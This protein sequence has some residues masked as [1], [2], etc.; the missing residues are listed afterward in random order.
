MPT[1]CN[2]LSA[3]AAKQFPY[4][5]Q[6]DANDHYVRRLRDLLDTAGGKVV[7]LTGAGVSTDS[8]IPDYRGP[9]GSYSWGHK[10]MTHDEFLSSEGNQKR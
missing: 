5:S 7:A 10:P 4:N 3:P 2:R 9:Q 1:S 8:G 6:S